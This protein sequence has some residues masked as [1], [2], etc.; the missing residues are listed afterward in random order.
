MATAM[1]RSSSVK[2][3]PGIESASCVNLIGVAYVQITRGQHLLL[4][5]RTGP[6]VITPRFISA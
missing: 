1:A 6:T 5:T 3:S 2:K 4:S